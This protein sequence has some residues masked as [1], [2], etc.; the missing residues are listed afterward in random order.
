MKIKK[1]FIII[2]KGNNKYSCI[3]L[4]SEDYEY[5]LGCLKRL[6]DYKKQLKKH[7]KKTK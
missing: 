2:I 3:N 1:M 7:M 4:E 6:Y 5:L